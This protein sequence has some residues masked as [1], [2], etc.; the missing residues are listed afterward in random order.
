MTPAEAFVT[1]L[2]EGHRTLDLVLHDVTP[3][4]LVWAPPG[5]ALPIGIIYAHA[6]GLE[7]LY[8]QQM[9]QQQPLVWESGSWAARLRHDLPP[10][11]WNIQRVQPP[12]MDALRSYQS[13]VFAAS[14]AYAGSLSGDELER[15]LEF[16]GRQWSMS[17]AQLLSVVVGH[18]LGHAGEIAALKGVQGARGLPF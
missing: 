8:I 15:R 1:L 18:T 2:S 10:N 5:N 17:I 12:D 13:E 7:D 3:E 4:M 16:P 11:Q 9:L 14:L 6:V